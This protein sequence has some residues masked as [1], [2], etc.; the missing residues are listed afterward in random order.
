[1]TAY[2]DVNMYNIGKEFVYLCSTKNIAHKCQSKKFVP[3]HRKSLKENQGKS[4]DDE[5]V[6][7]LTS[8]K[9]NTK[10]NVKFI[11]PMKWKE[12]DNVRVD[13]SCKDIHV[14]LYHPHIQF[15]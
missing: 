2:A 3:F 15:M 7:P 8:I 13:L 12:T 10:Y 9:F 11:E 1:M 4:M 14:T 5:I 6:I